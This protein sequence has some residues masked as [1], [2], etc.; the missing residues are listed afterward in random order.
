M[1]EWRGAAGVGAWGRGRG[2]GWGRYPPL[3]PLPDAN[4]S[5]TPSTQPPTHLFSPISPLPTK[6]E[7]KGHATWMGSVLLTC[8]KNQAAAN[9]SEAIGDKDKEC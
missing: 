8:V 1:P 9:Q 5:T 2:R 7:H 3:T 4:A 6:P